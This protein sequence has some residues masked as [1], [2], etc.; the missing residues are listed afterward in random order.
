MSVL[1]RIR[2]FCGHIMEDGEFIVRFKCQVFRHQVRMIVEL[3]CN[4][5]AQPVQPVQS[6]SNQSGSKDFLI[7]VTWCV[8][9]GWVWC[10]VVGGCGGWVWWWVLVGLCN[11]LV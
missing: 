5:L 1:L 9:D 4:T 11:G 6:N 8:V 2:H 10:G 7:V 3:Y